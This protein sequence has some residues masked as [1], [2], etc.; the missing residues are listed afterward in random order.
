MNETDKPRFAQIIAAT[1][2]VFNKSTTKLLADIYW[3]IL[4]E[5]DINDV[6]KAFINHIKTGK[7]FPAPTELI[8]LIESANNTQHIPADEA[9]GTV[10]GL[11]ANDRCSAVMTGEMC[12]AW[13]T[14]QVIYDQGDIVG[15]RVAFRAA[16]DRAV[17]YSK[18]NRRKTVWGF[19]PGTD[20]DNQRQVIEM[21]VAQGKLHE[22]SLEQFIGLP[23]TI[24][25]VPRKSRHDGPPVRLET[26]PPTKATDAKTARRHLME[27]KQ[28][29]QA[30]QRAF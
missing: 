26:H 24:A 6:E 16:Y 27:I 4:E 11:M 18:L 20:K 5:Y 8:F 25:P 13:Q 28:L 9:W 29:I 21:A 2:A 12:E 15:A 14:A 19:Y 3:R 30:K 23:S 7:F 22:S 17:N 1:A 10:L